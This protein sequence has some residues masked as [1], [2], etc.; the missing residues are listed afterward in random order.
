ML[1]ATVD[2]YAYATLRP[3]AGSTVTIRSLDYHTISKYDLDQPLVYDGQLDLVK[4]AYKRAV[5]KGYRFYSYGDA[6]LIV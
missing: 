3:N 4:A 2:K 6:M 1:N 5:K